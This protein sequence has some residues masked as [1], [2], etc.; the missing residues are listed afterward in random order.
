MNVRGDKDVA[1]ARQRDLPVFL[2]RVQDVPLAIAQNG[3]VS[4]KN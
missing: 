1:I 4:G 3:S 2:Q